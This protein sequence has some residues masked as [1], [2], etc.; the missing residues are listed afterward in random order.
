MNNGGKDTRREGAERRG[1]E[2]EGRR[3]REGLEKGGETALHSSAQRFRPFLTL[4][5][6]G[7]QRKRS[8]YIEVTRFS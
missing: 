8:I 6:N 7:T 4:G 3:G 1:R 5:I 2:E